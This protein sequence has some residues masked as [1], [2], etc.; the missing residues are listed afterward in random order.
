M[1]L[2]FDRARLE[3][4]IVGVKSALCGTR[5]EAMGGVLADAN[6][7]KISI[8]QIWFTLTNSGVA[9]EPV[10][11]SGSGATVTYLGADQ[12]INCEAC[13]WARSPSQGAS[14][15]SCFW[16]AKWVVGSGVHLDPRK[17]R[18]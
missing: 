7:A 15:T 8:D 18:G 9:A 5:V 3:A 11:L 2:K 1:A 12:A 13:E 16:S 4:M 6:P 14:E 10:D 17:R